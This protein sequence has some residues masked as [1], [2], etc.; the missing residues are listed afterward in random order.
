MLEVLE[1]LSYRETILLLS[2]PIITIVG[3]G[4][5]ITYHRNK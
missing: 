2:I 4:A 5:F 3:F 1:L